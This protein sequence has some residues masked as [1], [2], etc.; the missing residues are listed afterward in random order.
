MFK[1]GFKPTSASAPTTQ[2]SV[3]AQSDQ[4]ERKLM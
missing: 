3:P 2:T 4:P 1:K